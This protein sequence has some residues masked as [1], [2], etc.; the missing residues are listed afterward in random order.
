MTRY[1]NNGTIDNTFGTNGKVLTDFGN[2][3]DYGSSLALQ[4]DGKIVLAGHSGNDF[5]VARYNGGNAQTLQR[6]VAESNLSPEIFSAS[7]FPNPA[8]G[9]TKLR[10]YGFSDLPVEVQLVNMSGRSCRFKL[11]NRGSGLYDL[12]ATGLSKGS[13]TIIVKQGK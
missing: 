3:A 8:A 5:A 11:L 1:N 9:D 4:R 13:Y 12:S 2:K 7:L 10:L 6:P